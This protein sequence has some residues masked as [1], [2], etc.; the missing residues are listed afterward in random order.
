MVGGSITRLA[1]MMLQARVIARTRIFQTSKFIFANTTSSHHNTVF[2]LVYC[3]PRHFLSVKHNLEIERGRIR[4][5]SKALSTKCSL[6]RVVLP[7]PPQLLFRPSVLHLP[8]SEV[9][10]LKQTL[11]LTLT[12]TLFA[13]RYCTN[14]EANPNRFTSDDCR[15]G[16]CY[17][18]TCTAWSSSGKSCSWG[19]NTTVCSPDVGGPARIRGPARARALGDIPAVLVVAGG[20][21]PGF[22]PVKYDY[23]FGTSSFDDSQWQ[24]VDVPHDARTPL[25]HTHAVT[26]SAAPSHQCASLAGQQQATR[27]MLTCAIPV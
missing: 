6:L 10:T 5:A 19:D 24:L 13:T 7:P 22:Q 2:P 11:T 26:G 3:Y 15:I 14:L 25:S 23:S 12:L 1:K 9:P 4:S 8:F 18:P 20:H 27:C 16:C 21:R 17:E